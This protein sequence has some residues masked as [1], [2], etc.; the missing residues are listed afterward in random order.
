[1]H[2]GLVFAI[3]KDGFLMIFLYAGGC[4]VNFHFRVHCFYCVLLS[5]TTTDVVF[6]LPDR[7]RTGIE[8]WRSLTMFSESDAM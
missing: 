1:M 8:E 4:I 5:Q 2:G 6:S 3:L 7:Q